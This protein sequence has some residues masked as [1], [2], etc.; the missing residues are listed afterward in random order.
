M[1]LDQSEINGPSLRSIEEIC[2]RVDFGSTVVV[3]PNPGQQGSPNPCVVWDEGR[4]QWGVNEDSSGE[5]SE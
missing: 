5:D 1:F 3:G 4:H 2:A